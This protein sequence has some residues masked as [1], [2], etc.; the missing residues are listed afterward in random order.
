[1]ACRRVDG[2]QFLETDMQISKITD[3]NYMV[4]FTEKEHGIIKDWSGLIERPVR[5]VVNQLLKLGIEVF[6]RLMAGKD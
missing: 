6:L 5:D 2:G 1:M 3:Y 4:H